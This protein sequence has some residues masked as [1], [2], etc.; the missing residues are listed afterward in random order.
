MS[1]KDVA[2][3]AFTVFCCGGGDCTKAG[4]KATAKA[5]RHAVR[6][7]GLKEEVAWVRTHCTGRCQD[8]PVVIVCSGNGVQDDSGKDDAVCG[9]VW[10]RKLKSDDAQKLVEEHLQNGRPLAAKLM[11]RCDKES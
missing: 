11:S 7:A 3:A 10:Y 8:A 6:D 2:R 9:A 1:K 4:S 5:L